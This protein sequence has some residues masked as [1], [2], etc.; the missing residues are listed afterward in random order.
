[1]KNMLNISKEHLEVFKQIK[2]YFLPSTKIPKPDNWK[3]LTNN[4][5]WFHVVKQVMV[6]GS[7]APAE[8]FDKSSELQS[9][10]SYEKLLK[11]DDE[12]ELRD[13]FEQV[14]RAVG[15]LFPN[16][17]ADALVHNLKK[18]SG[19]Q[20]GPKGLL[21]RI[22][23]I[24]G[25]DI[26]RIK[27]LIKQDLK[28]IKNRGARDF[29]MDLGIVRDAVALDARIKNIF[30]KIGIHLPEEFIGKAKLYDEIEK[31]ILTKICKPIELS[32]VE[33]DRMLYQNYDKINL[34][35]EKKVI[36]QILEPYF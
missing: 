21:K 36:Q 34:F 22:S 12:T 5:I 23:E 7:S 19:F 17:K 10:I 32:G 35:L 4:D 20:D 15:S 3:S 16:R 30:E 13:Y 28:Y 31:E 2:N 26:R 24:D 27:Y 29:L 1:M 11:I 14:L 6:V 18:L 25:P 8:K 33:F 9:L